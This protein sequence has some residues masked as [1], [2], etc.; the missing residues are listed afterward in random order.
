MFAHPAPGSTYWERGLQFMLQ[1]EN[2]FNAP[3]HDAGLVWRLAPALL[4]HVIG[5]HGKA[6]LIV[7]WLGLGLLLTLSARLVLDRVRD[8]QLAFLFTTLLGTTS[9][10]LTVTGWLGLND[11]WY[12]SALMVVAFV[13]NRVA[14]TAALVI[15]PWIDERFIIALPLA[16]WIRANATG[17]KWKPRYALPTAGLSILLYFVIRG[18]NLA[19]LPTAATSD[20]WRIMKQG[21]FLQWLPWTALGWFMGLRAGWVLIAVAIGGKCRR[22]D[23]PTTVRP[24]FLALAPMLVITVLASDTGRTTTMI[25][26]LLLLGLERLLTLH[27]IEVTRRWLAWLLVANLL[28]PAMQV[29]FRSADIINVLPI[30]LVRWLRAG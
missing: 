12:A 1:A 9:A 5:L 20:Y 30:E 17:L 22:S 19:H 2:P 29:T 28:M 11:A 16:L 7:P 4:A 3:L 21:A 15:G 13:P 25:L 23:W 6:A 26:P 18:L 14:L 24:A 27:G 8:R 10:V